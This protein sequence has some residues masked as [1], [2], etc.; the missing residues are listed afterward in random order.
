MVSSHARHG[1]DDIER[2]DE[3]VLLNFQAR[4][5]L[6]MMMVSVNKNENVNKKQSN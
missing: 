1:E 6:G 4:C 2:L 3:D 5:V